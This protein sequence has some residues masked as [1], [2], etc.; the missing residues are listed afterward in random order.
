MQLNYCLSSLE[1]C[2]FIDTQTKIYL[3]GIISINLSANLEYISNML[4]LS[5]CNQEVSIIFKDPLIS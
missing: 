1:L 4:L 2:P 3:G 5:F